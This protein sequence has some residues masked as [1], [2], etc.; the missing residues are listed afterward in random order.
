MASKRPE[1]NIRLIATA[2]VLAFAPG[3]VAASDLFLCGAAGTGPGAAGFVNLISGPA[4]PP[5]PPDGVTEACMPVLSFDGNVT[6]VAGGGGGGG[7]GGSQPRGSRITV[8]L[9]RN[10][11]AARLTQ[12]VGTGAVLSNLTLVRTVRAPGSGDFRL[13]DAIALA[14][15]QVTSIQTSAAA[16]SG[17]PTD[18]LTLDYDRIRWSTWPD[19]FASPLPPAATACW[20]FASNAPC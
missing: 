11:N 20:K 16:G 14:Q 7:G 3:T 2:A 15:V 19:P 17:Q 4:N 6:L 10:V 8:V 18:V 9:P 1:P 5:A 13:A 12:L